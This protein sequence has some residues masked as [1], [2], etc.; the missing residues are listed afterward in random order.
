[1]RRQLLV[2]LVGWFGVW[3]AA[4]AQEPALTTVLVT[5]GV[6]A[7]LYVTHAPGDNDRLFVVD[8]CGQV[9]I[10][11]CGRLLERPFLDVESLVTCG[12]ER[13]LLGMAFHPDYA[14][15]GQ[16]FIDYTNHDGDTVIARYH[17]SNDPDAAD[18]T[19]ETVLSIHQPYSNHNGGW[20]DFGPDGYLYI[21][22]GDGGGAYDDAGT[23]Q[24]NTDLLASLL[25]IDVDGD[26][27]PEDPGRNYA[28]PPDNPFVD[29]DGADEVWAY[30]LRNPW[31]CAFDQLTGELYIGDVGQSAFEEIDVQS[32]DDPGG[33]NYGWVCKEGFG[34]T[35][36]ADEHCY[37]AS[38]VDPVHGYYHSGG[39]AIT[40][41][42]VYR[43]SAIPELQGTYFFSD[44]CSASISTF[45]YVDGEV[46]DLMDRTSELAPRDARTIDSV[47]SFGR[48]ASGELYICDLGGEVFKLVPA[49]ATA[50]LMDSDP[51]DGA[52][53]ARRP[54]DP[55]GSNPT[56]W[57]SVE[58]V[59]GGPAPALAPED[60]TVEQV[61]GDGD[62]P[63]VVDVVSVDTDRVRVD[64]SRPLSP[65]AWT[66]LVSCDNGV[67]VRLGY[68]PAD[69]NG[70]GVSSAIDILDFID[71]LNGVGPP[72]S[73]WSLDIDRSGVVNATDVLEII[74]LLH[75]ADA[76]PAYNLAR[77]P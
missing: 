69:V 19:G 6:T 53:D 40:G 44:I 30:G 17:V 29:T 3:A 41:G 13:G 54:F 70:D 16:F 61:G 11:K 31:R 2:G 21:A 47:S 77:L 26:D 33:A 58:L 24:D 76:Y 56:G 22:M 34:F 27:F 63:V 48:D 66:T 49:D 10:V 8:Q 45:R 59:F 73:D 68:L 51:P 14:D 71:E 50:P 25:R 12:G 60:F 42:E 57:D 35:G 20:I 72:R 37:T 43:G 74:D 23:S 5:D 75:G 15:N 39:C 67:Y 9:R 32:A 7:P 52:I 36:Y 4:R 65:G 28:T 62:A 18:P 64:L 55:D 46:T 1:M 38:L